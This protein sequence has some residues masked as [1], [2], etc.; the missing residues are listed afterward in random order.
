MKPDTLAWE[1]QLADARGVRSIDLALPGV[2]SHPN[3][4]RPRKIGGLEAAN[5]VKY[6][7]CSVSNFNNPDGTITEREFARM[8]VVARTGCGIITNQGAYPDRAGYGKAYIRQLSIAE[9]RFIGGFA[10]I[11]DMIHEAGALGV[12]QILHAGRYGGI[13]LDHTMQPSDVP[14]TLRHFRPP[15]AM[16]IADI[17]GVIEEHAQAAR[18]ACEAG[19][20]GVEITS[21]MGYL[22]S[23]FLSPF[24]NTRTD[25][26]GGD[27]EG[28]GRFMIELLTALREVIGD[29]RMLWVRLNGAEL[30]DDHGGNSEADCLEF[31]K[32]AERAGVDGISLV[33]GWHESTRGALGRDVPSDHWLRL[34]QAAKQAVSVPIAFGPRFGDAEM[35]EAAL[36]RGDFDFWELCRPMLAD[37]L[38]LHK[39]AH[40]AVGDVRPCTGG[41]V[42]LSRMFRNLPYICSVNPR[43]GHECEPQMQVTP[44]SVKRRVLVIG[45]GPA[46][47]EAS[48][49]AARRGHEVELWE[50][51]PH[52][53][54]Q[55]LAASREVGGGEVFLRL[56]DYY[57]RQLER[58]GVTVR[59][60]TEATGRAVSAH[61]PEVCVVAT[62]AGVDVH[63]VARQVPSG[64][65]VW[66]ADDAEDPPAG[67]R[68]VVLGVDRTALVAAEILG[69]EGRDVTMVA[70]PYRQ[71]WDVAPTFKW[72]HAA[73]V[74]EF[75]ITVLKG[76]E[77]AG[78]NDDDEL[79]LTGEHAGAVPVDLLVAGQHRASRQAL[80]SELEYRVDVLHVVGDAV[81][82][83][84]VC[85]AVHSGYRTAVDI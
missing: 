63:P 2:R 40:D 3:L 78:W 72:R 60:E 21:F 38:L 5:S 20:D 59:L 19:F 28:R 65:T 10:R 74:K 51:G 33:V 44:S 70:G 66:R 75:D 12:Q 73:W 36:G 34:A 52:L 8:D 85:Q 82:P 25:R 11:A 61:A 41:L 50:R 81:S 48:L 56:I 57:R 84:S 39:V 32:M 46:G 37:P 31:M 58:T 26:Y 64:V 23:N 29:Q 55:L 76:T 14:Q 7:A 54:G 4:F 24:T 49:V 83:Q 30:M 62:G 35:A 43:L 47:L 79:L 45:G 53:G 13:D 77:A 42:C 15:R 6:A 22:L 67:Q 1:D 17:E 9:D 16:S 68:V 80:L 18:R 69:Q 27:L 71:A